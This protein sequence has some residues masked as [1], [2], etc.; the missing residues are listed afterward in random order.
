MHTVILLHCYTV[1]LIQIQIYIGGLGNL[2][3]ARRLSTKH[4]IS[5]SFWKWLDAQNLALALR[6]VAL[7]GSL[8]PAGLEQRLVDQALPRKNTRKNTLY[9]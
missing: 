5:V 8:H 7:T 4:M 3:R 6:E 9:P 1:T 2:A